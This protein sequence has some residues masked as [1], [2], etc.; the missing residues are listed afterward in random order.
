MQMQFSQRE[1]SLYENLV[2]KSRRLPEHCSSESHWRC[3]RRHLEQNMMQ[4]RVPNAVLSYTTPEKQDG[5]ESSA[6][7]F[8]HAVHCST[9]RPA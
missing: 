9:R 3:T 2:V 5:K 1:F 6:F 4:T 7:S 8:L